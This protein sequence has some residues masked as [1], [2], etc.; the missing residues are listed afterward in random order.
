MARLA[1]TE[2]VA[3]PSCDFKI[4]V[5]EEAQALKVRIG[6]PAHGAPIGR[7]EC[8]ARQCAKNRLVTYQLKGTLFRSTHAPCCPVTG[9]V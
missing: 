6:P 8:I 7:L 2:G 3:R 5:R 1:C 9:R 4:R